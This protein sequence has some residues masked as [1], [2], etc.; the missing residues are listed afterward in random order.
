MDGRSVLFNICVFAFLANL[1]IQRPIF[2]S[3][4]SDTFKL[5]KALANNSYVFNR[6]TETDRQ[7]LIFKSEF[8]TNNAH[9]NFFDTANLQICLSV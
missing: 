9:T 8:K 5:P 1:R 6:V 3:I 7:L 4:V 2:Y